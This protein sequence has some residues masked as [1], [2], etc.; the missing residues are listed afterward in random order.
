[1]SI[2]IRLLSNKQVTIENPGDTIV[3]AGEN[4]ATDITVAFP[5]EHENYSKRADFLNARGQG[6]T[7]G[8]Y[9]P[10]LC[11]YPADTDKLTHTFKLPNAVTV[12]GEMRMQFISY[13]PDTDN[14][15]IPFR[16]I[17]LTVEGSIFKYD[18]TAPT[19]PPDLLL[20]AVSAA[21]TALQTANEAL[22]N[23]RDAEEVAD[24]VRN[25]ADAGA[26]NGDKGDKGEKGDKGDKGDRGERGADGSN[27]V[28]RGRFDPAENYGINQGVE[29]NGSYYIRKAVTPEYISKFV[30]LNLAY[31]GA[32][33][34]GLPS[35]LSGLPVTV[36]INGLVPGKVYRNTPFSASGT[37]YHGG[38]S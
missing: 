8:L 3:V 27:I 18:T 32:T 19:T 4:L 23:S 30:P 10:E 5:T 21:N 36:H 26:F 16:V 11:E 38:G 7:I 20:A 6:W 25:D 29:Y 28:W 24:S 14:T 35:S 15:V 12:D 37:V 22:E 17:P 31:D 13:I 34:S 33:F 9:T 1:M 2:R